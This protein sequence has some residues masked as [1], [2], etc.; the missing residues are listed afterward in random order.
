MLFVI[1]WSCWQVIILLMCNLLVLAIRLSLWI[2]LKELWTESEKLH[3][4]KQ[5][6]SSSGSIERMDRKPS[7]KTRITAACEVAKML[8]RLDKT[9]EEKKR[10]NV[11]VVFDE[12]TF[13]FL[14]GN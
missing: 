7:F 3:L 14:E 2:K 8:E 5:I 6:T 13:A 11:K 10:N 1:W 4:A 12:F 9:Y